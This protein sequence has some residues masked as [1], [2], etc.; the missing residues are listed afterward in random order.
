MAPYMA[1]TLI[2]IEQADPS[3]SNWQ[4]HLAPDGGVWSIPIVAGCQQSYFG[5]KR[6]ILRLLREGMISGTRFNEQGLT[7]LQGL[8]SKFTGEPKAI[9][10][11]PEKHAYLGFA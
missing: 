7:W 2:P 11:A 10:Q 5:D 9:F 6:H 1:N 3:Q 4:L 8:Q